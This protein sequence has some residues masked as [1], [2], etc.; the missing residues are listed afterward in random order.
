MPARQK[1]NGPPAKPAPASL[2]KP[3]GGA[4]F[5]ELPIELILEPARAARETF[6]EQELDGLLQSIKAVG[7]IEPLVVQR[8][9]ENYRV[10]AG[11]RRLIAC[12]ALGYQKVACVIRPEGDQMGEAVKAHENLFRED[13]NPAQEA[14]YLAEMLETLGEGDMDV[15]AAK[16]K[17]ARTYIDG[18]LQL[19]RGDPRVLEALGANTISVGVAQELNKVKDPQ[20]RFM[21]LD[22]AMQ[23]GASITMVRDWRVRANANA[24]LA[25]TDFAPAVDAG[26]LQPVAP[27][28]TMTCFLCRDSSDPWELEV[29]YAHKR[30]RKIILDRFLENLFGKGVDESAPV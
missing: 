9:G 13:L 20:V 12:R 7:L 25:G 15:L 1:P 2:P 28:V 24:S 11:H 18:R 16:L 27:I 26:P 22:A 4:L 3:S 23:G 19:L 10:R 29:L 14:R 17:L 21:Y 8:E 5:D 30:C 6:G